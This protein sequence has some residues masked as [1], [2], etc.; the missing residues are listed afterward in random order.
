MSAAMTAWV[1][2]AALRQQHE[3]SEAGLDLTM[4]VNISARR[5]TRGSDLPDTVARLTAKWNIVPGRLIL[6]LTGFAAER[7]EKAH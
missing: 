7:S 2:D 3:W 6:E 1:L 5:L 4:A